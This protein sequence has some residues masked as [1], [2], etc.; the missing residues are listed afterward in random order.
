MVHDCLGAA[1]LL[2]VWAMA[3]VLAAAMTAASVD[4]RRYFMGKPRLTERSAG[5]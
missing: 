3:A 4:A 2:G 1:A 5:L